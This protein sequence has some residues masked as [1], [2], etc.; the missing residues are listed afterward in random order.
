[1][2]AP[3]SGKRSAY[4]A[5]ESYLKDEQDRL[6]DAPRVRDQIPSDAPKGTDLAAGLVDAIRPPVTP[7]DTST[8]SEPKMRIIRKGTTVSGQQTTSTTA[9]PRRK[10]QSARMGRRAGT[11]SLRIARTSNTGQ[12]NLNY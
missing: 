11:R 3:K 7:K 5:S 4:K 6:G 2:C 10:K 12:G 9:P 8:E 1:M